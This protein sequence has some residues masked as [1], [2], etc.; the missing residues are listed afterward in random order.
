MNT[1][2]PE[3]RKL[4][5]LYVGR[6]I[7]RFTPYKNGLFIAFLSRYCTHFFYYPI[8]SVLKLYHGVYHFHP[9][10]SVSFSVLMNSCPG[11]QSRALHSLSIV[12]K[13]IL[14][15]LSWYSVE[16]VP[17]DTPDFSASW[18]MFILF[19]A[20]SKFN[21]H[22]IIIFSSLPSGKH[23]FALVLTSVVILNH[24]VQYVKHNAFDIV[25]F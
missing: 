21:V 12:S 19:L 17:L 4:F 18:T 25:Q 5:V 9:L 20:I 6:H 10:F 15:A 22:I 24:N 23:S 2:F 11:E 7:L 16:I 14:F 1:G 8:F 3:S 13:S